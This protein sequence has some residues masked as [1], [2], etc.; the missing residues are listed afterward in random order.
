MFGGI[1][2]DQSIS[3]QSMQQKLTQFVDI[4]RQDPAIDSGQRVYRRRADQ[5]RLCL[6][7]L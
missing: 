2:A 3:F 4:M 6:C 5:F 1:Q 7:R